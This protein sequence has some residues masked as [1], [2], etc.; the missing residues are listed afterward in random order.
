[1]SAR[2]DHDLGG[3]AGESVG[4]TPSVRLFTGGKIAASRG[5]KLAHSSG[6]AVILLVLFPFLLLFYSPLAW[7]AMAVAIGLICKRQFSAPPRRP[8]HRSIDHDA[9][10]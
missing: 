3:A 8:V 10:I 7:V 2:T 9:S 5:R 4:D 1:M 6:M